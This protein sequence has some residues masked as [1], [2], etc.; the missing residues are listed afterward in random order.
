MC[1][2]MRCSQEVFGSITR[3]QTCCTHTGAHNTQ[4]LAVGWLSLLAPA[5]RIGGQKYHSG[6][7]LSPFPTANWCASTP[8][9]STKAASSQRWLLEGMFQ[10]DKA[11]LTTRHH[12]SKKQTRNPT[13]APVTWNATPPIKPAASVERH[14]QAGHP[15]ILQSL[16]PQANLLH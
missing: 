8:H 7:K 5:G 9:C 1:K 6:T 2:R 12:L 10:Q 11:L 14:P 4:G 15:P 13:T 16:H 3:C